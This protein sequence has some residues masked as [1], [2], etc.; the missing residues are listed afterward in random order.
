MSSVPRYYLMLLPLLLLGWLLLAVRLAGWVP[1]KFSGIVLVAMLAGVTVPNLLRC[2]KVIAEQR[3]IQGDK[4]KAKWEHL[5]R[6]GELIKR[7]VPADKRVLGGPNAN[8]MAYVSDRDVLLRRALFPPELRA[9][10]YPRQLQQMRIEY[11][12]L[13]ASLYLSGEH[14]FREMME[15]G[16]IVPI[17]KVASTRDLVLAKV[18]IV[19]VSGD[20]R[21]MPLVR[22]FNSRSRSVGNQATREARRSATRPT[23]RKARKPRR[24]AAPATQAASRPVGQK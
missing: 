21:Q 1:A 13:P 4:D 22:G 3:G 19:Q 11:A 5:V 20:W 24:T 7:R 12:V 18:K 23:T 17:R 2:G 14:V 10:Q 9:A 15:R 8:V 16:V 6:M